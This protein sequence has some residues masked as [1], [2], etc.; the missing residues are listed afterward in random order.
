MVRTHVPR[1]RI[2]NIQTW[3]L[4]TGSVDQMVRCVVLG[5][6]IAIEVA[7]SRVNRAPWFLY[8]ST[9]S[10]SS[11]TAWR[12]R[13]SRWLSARCLQGN[14]CRRYLL[15]RSA[16]CTSSLF[17]IL[18]DASAIASQTDCGC[19]VTENLELARAALRWFPVSSD[20]A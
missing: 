15:S 18:P 13:Y 5:G 16:S 7:D 19:C 4:P 8:P 20:D 11:S 14:A 2:Q 3:R 10:I 12:Y 17:G 6:D 1:K 9:S